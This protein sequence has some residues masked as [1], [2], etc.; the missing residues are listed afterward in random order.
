LSRVSR[1]RENL[2]EI[3]G[4]VAYAKERIAI[5]RRGKPYA[6]LIP[7][8]DLDLLELSSGAADR[9]NA[10][11]DRQGSDRGITAHRRTEDALRLARFSLDRAGVRKRRMVG[12]ADQ[13]YRSGCL[14]G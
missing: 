9:S 10:A 8:D 7:V 3:L 13:R 11:A 14:A 5:E 12:L 6:V 4:R 2:S 1:A